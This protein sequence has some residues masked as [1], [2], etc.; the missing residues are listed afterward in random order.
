MTR[1]VRSHVIAMAPL[2][3]RELQRNPV[4]EGE[5]RC[6]RR[7][8]RIAEPRSPSTSL[9]IAPPCLPRLAPHSCS[10]PSPPHDYHPT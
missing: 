7:A 10:R 9:V 3:L 6:E 8:G 5:A 4:R 2:L 1:G